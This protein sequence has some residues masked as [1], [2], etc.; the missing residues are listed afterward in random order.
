M[1]PQLTMFFLNKQIETGIIQTK[2]SYHFLVFLITDPITSSG[3][4]KRRLLYKRTINTARKKLFKKIMAKNSDYINK[5]DNLNEAYSKFLYDFFSLY[6]EAFLK[7]EIKIKQK[8]LI[9]P[10]IIKEIM[11]SL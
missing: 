6:E 11:K 9:S 10:W 1:Q 4:D 8:V 5:I 7:L 3:T 2:I